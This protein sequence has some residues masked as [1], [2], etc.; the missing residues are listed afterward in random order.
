MLRQQ[1]ECVD[2][3]YAGKISSSP[4]GGVVF[5]A[6]RLR[7]REMVGGWRQRASGRQGLGSMDA[8]MEL[9]GGARSSRRRCDA[10]L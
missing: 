8:H 2:D 4:R 9:A 10:A 6:L 5:T 1:S 7:D 3:A